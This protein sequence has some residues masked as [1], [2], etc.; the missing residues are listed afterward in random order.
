[1]TFLIFV[2]FAVIVAVFVIFSVVIFYHI[3]RYS[4]L[5]DYSK[6]AF[7][8]YSS[9]SFVV[10]SASFILLILNHIFTP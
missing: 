10:V 1:M 5:G 9:L 2:I 8:Y 3:S 4:Y 7:F 6:K